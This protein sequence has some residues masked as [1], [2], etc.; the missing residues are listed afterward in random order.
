MLVYFVAGL[1]G[2][3]SM[4]IPIFGYSLETIGVGASGAISGLVGLGILISPGK[5]VMFP[6]ILPLPFA[7]AGA[8]YLIATVSGLFAPGLIAYSA[9]LFG[10]LSGAAFGFAW[11][12]N[13]VKNLIVFVLMLFLIVLLPYILEFVLTLASAG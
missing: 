9:H 13:K 1:A 7:I 10:F 2:N 3:L 6:A 5:L 12:E 4:F 11:S 8:I